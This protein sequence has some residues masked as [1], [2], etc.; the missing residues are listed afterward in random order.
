MNVSAEARAEYDVLSRL[1]RLAGS[2]SAWL[3]GVGILILLLLAF[4][5][6][7]EVVLRALFGRPIPGT[8]EIIDSGMAIAIAARPTLLEAAV[9]MTMSPA[10]SFAMSINAP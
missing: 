5:T 8:N 9:M 4:M 1:D 6:I 2:V 10:V 7:S 3:A